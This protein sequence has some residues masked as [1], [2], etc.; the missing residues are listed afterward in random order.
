QLR[1]YRMGP[2]LELLVPHAPGATQGWATPGQDPTLL[3]EALGPGP[4]GG[5]LTWLMR[6]P[7]AWRPHRWALPGEALVF[8]PDAQALPEGRPGQPLQAALLLC[9]APRQA[10]RWSAGPAPVLH[11][12]LELPA[13]AL[14]PPHA[15]S[16][17][18]REVRELLGSEPGPRLLLIARAG[19]ALDRHWLATLSRL[20]PD[21]RFLVLGDLGTADEP[22]P[23]SCR[24]LGTLAPELLPALLQACDAGLVLAP[25]GAATEHLWPELP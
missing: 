10:L 2:A 9:E 25:A 17:E 8:Q 13:C 4:E 5:T 6:W 22:W 1:R 16:Y 15:A 7:L 12:P 11:L 24:G 19:Q 23:D 3:R 21:W 20:R 14:R 18:A